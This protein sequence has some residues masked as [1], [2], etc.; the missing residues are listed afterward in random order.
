MRLIVLIAAGLAAAS[1]AFCDE[2]VL[3][4]CRLEHPNHLLSIEAECGTLSVA[5]N[6][7]AP[8]GRR[9][10]LNVAR[11]PAINRRKQPDPLFVLAGGPGMAAT[12]FYTSV[13]PVFARIHRDR[14]IVLVDQRGTGRSNG[15]YCKMDD[16]AL[17]RATD[18]VWEAQTRAC[19]ATLSRH[20]DV[21]FYTT[22]LAVSDLDRVRAALGYSVVNLYGV[23]Y[24]TRVAQ[25]YLRRYPSHTRAVALDGVV[26][27]GAAVGALLALHAERA[28]A[29]ILERC[30]ADA[31]CHARFGDPAADYRALRTALAIHPVDVTV[32]D[33]TSAEPQKLSFDALH[34]AAVLRL[35]SYTAEQAALLPLSLSAA[36]RDGNFAPLAAQFLLIDRSYENALA[37]GMHNSVVCTEDVPFY[38]V[39]AAERAQLAATYLGTAQLDGLIA[40]CAVWPRGPMDP[41]FHAPLTATTPVLLLSGGNDPVTPAADALQAARGLTHALSVTIPGAGHGQL[42]APCVDRVLA[43]FFE[44]GSVRGLDVSCTQRDA[45]LPFFTSFAG[46]PP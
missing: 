21:A 33:P 13:A 38:R 37:Y 35:G 19:L 15:L 42:A 5:E 43:R 8:Q 10:A 9:I 20:A 26:P 22:S 3:S 40:V 36:H 2:L 27:P 14:D 1:P 32:A 25:H 24:G 6:P 41:D 46:P 28:L 44:A 11:V 23:S 18:V 7:A 29:Q 39:S 17:W 4:R 16:D 34:L 30:A 31:A 45:P 12:T